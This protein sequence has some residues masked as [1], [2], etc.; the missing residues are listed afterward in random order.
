MKEKRNPL[1]GVGVVTSRTAAEFVKTVE[2][3]DELGV[4]KR[5]DAVDVLRAVNAVEVWFHARLFRFAT[6]H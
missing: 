4:T 3:P 5:G 6:R 2:V 1:F